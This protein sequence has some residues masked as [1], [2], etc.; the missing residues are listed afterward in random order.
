MNAFLRRFICLFALAGLLFACG[1]TA[2]GG[3]MRRRLRYVA[4]PHAIDCGDSLFPNLIPKNNAC[5]IGASVEHAPF[6]IRWEIHDGAS[7]TMR[8]IAMNNGGL[9]FLVTENLNDPEHELPL[10]PCSTPQLVPD[11]A[12]TS[13]KVLTCAP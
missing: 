3:R 2:D 10:T 6:Y 1:C 7:S 11:P 9:M 4:G 12:V 8:G 5:A 13:M